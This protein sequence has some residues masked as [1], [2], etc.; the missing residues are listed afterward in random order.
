[1]TI[2]EAANLGDW[3][4]CGDTGPCDAPRCLEQVEHYVDLE[5]YPLG[6]RITLHYCKAHFE[7]YLRARD[8]VRERER[9]E[10]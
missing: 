4:R 1:V 8:D 9:Y 6:P 10:P 2:E 7:E 5:R 3:T